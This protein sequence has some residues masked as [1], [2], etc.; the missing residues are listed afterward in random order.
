MRC[1]LLSHFTIIHFD[2]KGILIIREERKIFD[3]GSNFLNQ[4]PANL[5]T[6]DLAYPVCRFP[7]DKCLCLLGHR[8]Q[9]PNLVEK[10]FLSVSNPS[11]KI[12]SLKRHNSITCCPSPLPAVQ[13]IYSKVWATATNQSREIRI[14]T[15][16]DKII[17]LCFVPD[18][19]DIR[20]VLIELD[21]YRSSWFCG[22]LLPFQSCRHILIISKTVNDIAH[23]AS[24]NF[25][26]DA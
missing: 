18:Y 7:L 9:S 21:Q 1:R 5:T 25:Y 14:C 24:G 11:F 23:R 4:C 15:S 2:L 26:Y 19:T 17:G 3:T 16:P 13:N 10:Y 22:K 6:L 12:G 8:Q 20:N